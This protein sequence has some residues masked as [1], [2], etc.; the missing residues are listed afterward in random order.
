MLDE[1]VQ[2]VQLYSNIYEHHHSIGITY[3][4][5]GGALEYS[6]VLDRPGLSEIASLNAVGAGRFAGGPHGRQG[7]PVPAVVRRGAA[8]T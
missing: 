5:E 2:S 3:L 1:L 8:A 4:L 6:A 7:K